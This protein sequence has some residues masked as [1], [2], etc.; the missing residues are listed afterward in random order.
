MVTN[1]DA[2]AGVR[3]QTGFSYVAHTIRA[4]Q[5]RITTLNISRYV[6]ASPQR[7]FIYKDSKRAPGV[8]SEFFLIQYV[9]ILRFKS[10]AE[11]SKLLDNTL[12]IS[13][14]GWGDE[15]SKRKPKFKY[16]DNKWRSVVFY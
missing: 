10:E 8:R 14:I 5:K 2:T 12:V 16:R 6:D 15:I 3:V 13:E 11:E 9:L 4:C 1:F 7:R